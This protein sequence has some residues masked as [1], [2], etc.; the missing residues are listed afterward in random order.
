M[1]MEALRSYALSLPETTEEPHFHYASFRVKGKIFVTVP[2]DGEFVHVFVGDEQRDMAI[3]VHPD[4]VEALTWGQKT[5]GVRIAVAQADPDFVQELIRG[6][7]TRKAP[8]SLV[9]SAKL[10]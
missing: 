3:A 8:K 5:V 4:V 10:R 1:Q 7:W 6:A 2:P 9:N